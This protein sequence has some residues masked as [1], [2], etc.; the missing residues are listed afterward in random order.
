MI[1]LI[2][3]RILFEKFSIILFFYVLFNLSYFTSILSAQQHGELVR[4]QGDDK[5]YIIQNGQKRLIVKEELFNQ[6]GFKKEDIKELDLNILMSIPEG[7]PL[8]SKEHLSIYPDGTLIRPKGKAQVYLIKGGR[9]CFIPDAETFHAQGFRWEQVLELEETIFN[10]I[11]TGIPLISIK[12]PYQYGSPGIPPPHT[13][14]SP[15]SSPPAAYPPYPPH[16]SVPQTYTPT[17]PTYPARD[18]NQ[19]YSPSSPVD[20]PPNPKLPK[21]NSLFLIGIFKASTL[22]N[23]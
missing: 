1:N 15:Y 16:P 23:I 9:K 22:Q 5:I 10:S 11:P 20:N 13:P 3:S 7:P 8:L 17:S 21:N 18:Y 12:T 4:A 6:M 19:P 2:I 14:G